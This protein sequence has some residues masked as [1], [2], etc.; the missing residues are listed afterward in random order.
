ME[1]HEKTVGKMGDFE[2]LAERVGN[3]EK[4]LEK[5]STLV[6]KLVQ[7]DTV[8]GSEQLLYIDIITD[9]TLSCYTGSATGKG[10]GKQRLAEYY[11][12]RPEDSYIPSGNRQSAHCQK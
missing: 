1:H 12:I 4:N 9:H 11:R 6:E 3:I 2:K 7:E 10:G 8:M 5:L